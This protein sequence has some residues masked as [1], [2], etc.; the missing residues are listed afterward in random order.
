MPHCEPPLRNPE[1]FADG[2]AGGFPGGAAG[3]AYHFDNDMAEKIFQSFFGGMGGMGG[4][5]GMGDGGGSGPRVRVFRSG[6][7]PG[8]GGGGMGGMGGMPG[9][10]GLF[11]SMFGGAGQGGMDDILGGGQDQFMRGAAN[12]HG[13]SPMRQGRGGAPP[14]GKVEAP[15]KVRGW[16]SC[17]NCGFGPLA[18]SD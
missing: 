17:L 18:T 15:L 13:P 11:G 4:F 12:G 3:G 5:G 8:G 14:P 6:G 7:M 16:T 1:P 2:G 10:G 9:M